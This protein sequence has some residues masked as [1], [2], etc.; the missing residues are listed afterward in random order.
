MITDLLFGF[1]NI[2][3]DGKYFFF[4][5]FDNLSKEEVMRRVGE[6]LFDRYHFGDVYLIRSGK[7]FHLVNFTEL[8]SLSEYLN[9]LEDI[10]AD[11]SFIYWVRR[12]GYAVLRL[13]RRSSHLKVPYL[14]GVLKSPYHKKENKAVRDFYFA[15]LSLESKIYK[16]M[17]VEVK[18]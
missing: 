10:G 16:V 1:V 2:A 5:D 9:V 11:P 7:G 8:L 15:L 3:Q 17:R 12:V 4:A 14:V 13:S 6:V 18:T